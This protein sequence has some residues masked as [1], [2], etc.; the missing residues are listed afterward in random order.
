[1][2]A[3]E[4]IAAFR[5]PAQALVEQRITK[6]MLVEQGAP[7]ASDKHLIT[8]AVEELVWHVALKPGTVGIPAGDD[9]IELALLSLTLRPGATAA[10][11][12]RVRQLIH[13]AIPYP[14]LLVC[15][16]AG[17]ALL[18]VA[19]KR[20]SQAEAGQWVTESAVETDALSPGAP[21]GAEADFLAS[22]ALDRMP[23]SAVANL[24]ALYQAY[25]HR[26]TALAAARITG[27]FTVASDPSSAAAQRAALA[28]RQRAVQQLSAAR[29]AALKEKQIA[30]RVQLNLKIQQLQNELKQTE[31]RLTA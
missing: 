12:Q 26:I 11:A 27:R 1:M 6:K 31:S 18:S 24:T 19:E 10:Q 30:R 14:V 28:D 3:Q 9:V 17:A 23:R 7:T 20:A 16:G 25:V 15:D 2:T 13:R 5:L 21:A 29:T 8:A 4:L 22:L